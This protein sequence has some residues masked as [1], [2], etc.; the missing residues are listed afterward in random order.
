M[1]APLTRHLNKV[2]PVAALLASQILFFPLVLVQLEQFW[3]VVEESK[4]T[5]LS[6]WTALPQTLAYLMTNPQPEQPCFAM[7]TNG[8]DI[9]FVKLLQSQYAV[10]RLF[11]P[12]TS[13]G[14]LRTVLQILKRLGQT[15]RE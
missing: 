12:Y 6:A 4:K 13:S 3:V 11:S 14:E 5:T 7:V 10:S 1:L 9:L 8:D 15:L 2:L